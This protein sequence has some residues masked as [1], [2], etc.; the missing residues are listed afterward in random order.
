MFTS[1][2]PICPKRKHWFPFVMK[3]SSTLETQLDIYWAHHQFDTGKLHFYAKNI[4][5]WC[6]ANSDAGK[7]TLER[8]IIIKIAAA[9]QSSDNGRAL[10]YAATAHSACCVTSFEIH[11]L[12]LRSWAIGWILFCTN[13]WA[14]SQFTFNCA[15][16]TRRNHFWDTSNNFKNKSLHWLRRHRHS[17]FIVL[18]DI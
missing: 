15:L 3:N 17:L 7:N 10:P 5:N 18:L 6:L 14:H 16:G 8:Y 12:S 13:H 11:H 9:L 4:E 1:N 2:V